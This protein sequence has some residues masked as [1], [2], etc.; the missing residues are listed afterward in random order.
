[1]NTLTRTE[2]LTRQNRAF[3]EWAVVCDALRNG[4]MI[5]LLRKGGIRE[6]EGRF[7]VNDSSFLLLPTYE[8]QNAELLR[9]EFVERLKDSQHPPTG[10]N[11]IIIDT[12]A[13]VDTVFPLTDEKHLIDLR[14]EH[15]WN[16]KYEQLRLNF[17]PYD[18]LYVMILRA[19]RLPVPVTLPMTKDYEGCKSWVTLTEFLSLEHIVPAIPDE[20]FCAR[21][22]RILDAIRD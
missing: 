17:N 12:Y 22:N 14:P 18:P 9:P 19:Y 13:V 3:K 21:R 7:E 1:M 2:D 8:H 11:N 16:E 5:A 4:D 15:V 10:H 20:Q 6:E